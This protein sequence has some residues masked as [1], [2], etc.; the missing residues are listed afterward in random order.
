MTKNC[1]DLADLD[2]A[3]SCAD[4]DN[5]GGVVS[6]LIFGYYDDVATWPDLPKSTDTASLTLEAAGKLDGDLVMKTA[7]CAHKLVFTDDS[8]EFQI[9][10]QGEIG[11]MSFKYTLSIVR[12]KMSAVIF[13][14]ENATRG[15]RMFL[16]VQDRNGNYYLMG[17]ALTPARR[18]TGDA[19]TTGKASTE[20]NKN[21]L[22][23]EYS[24]PRKLMYTGDVV[25]ILTA[26]TAAG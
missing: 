24:S 11:G 26:A 15:R 14:F 25:K 9:T 1:V 17:D 21:P 10:P 20:L 5:I 12:A 3:I 6:T 4:L 22:N 23:F 18:V 13:G 7:T 19:S 8:G 2:E 16:I